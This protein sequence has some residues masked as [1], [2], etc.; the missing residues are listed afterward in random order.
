MQV[1]AYLSFDGRCE[2]ALEFYRGAIGA[3]VVGLMRFKEM[4]D[5]PPGAVTPANESKVMHSAFR[6]G[7]STVMASD[8][9]SQ[10]GRPVFQGVTLALQV[11]DR[12]EAEKLFASLSRGGQ[13]QMP[14]G[15]TFF[16]DG[17]GTLTDKFGVAWMVNVSPENA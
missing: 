17:F 1:Q 3:E 16:S 12:A 5:A 13:V 2:E 8:G 4:P 15:K 9:M 10:G 11:A 7:K 14:L 6:V